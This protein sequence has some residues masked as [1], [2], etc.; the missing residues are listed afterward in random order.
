MPTVLPLQQTETSEISGTQGLSRRSFLLRA[1]QTATALFV[2]PT[3]LNGC[4]ASRESFVSTGTPQTGL[5]LDSLRARLEGALLEPSSAGFAQAVSPWNLRYVDKV[6]AALA[7]CGSIEDILDCLAWAE[8]N[9]VPFAAR[10][11]GHSYSAFSSSPGLMVDISGL[12]SVE[13]D[14]TS[15]RVKLGPGARNATVY[16]AL[17]PLARAVT[18]GRCYEVGVSGLC[19]GGGIGFNMRLHGLTCDQLVETEILLADRQVL[20]LNENQNSDLFWA[21][22]GAG[23]GNYGI[24]TSFTFQTFPVDSVTFFKIDWTDNLDELFPLLMD[25][26]PTA[27]RELG[28][29]IS[30][31]VRRD[32]TGQ[33]RL[34]L[35]LL[36]Q[37]RG[38]I[39]DLLA[40]FQPA[41]D[42]VDPSADDIRELPYWEA[43]DRLS[44]EGDPQYSYERSHLVNNPI[45]RAGLSTVLSF[46]RAWPGMDGLADWK[47]FLT[48]GAVSDVP[49]DG[50]AYVHRQALGISSVELEW[51]KPQSDEVVNPNLRWVDEFHQA[52]A[53]FTSRES[54]QNFIDASQTDYLRAYYGSNLERLVEVKQKYDPRNVFNYPQSIPVAL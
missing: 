44:E 8:D 13:M 27:P 40:F 39:P 17:R 54:Y 20:T 52:M 30:I 26:L 12:R 41:F 31:T 50:T 45:S 11:G 9:G 46:L 29:K 21:C 28:V 10:S 53:A 18:H 33:N 1:A 14:A 4:G 7:R 32:G 23:G 15:G 49:S 34:N 19:L 5:P 37:L 24:H 38:P 16:D 3:L 36:G 25:L 47:M 48:G 22:R 2:A 43:Q 51:H 42:L 6:P 35:E